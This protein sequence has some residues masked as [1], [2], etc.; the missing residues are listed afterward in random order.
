MDL[1]GNI[2]KRVFLELRGKCLKVFNGGLYYLKDNLD[3]EEWELFYEP[4]D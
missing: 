1:K 4:I 2:L 3:N